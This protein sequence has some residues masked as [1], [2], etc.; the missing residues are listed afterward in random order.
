LFL[1]PS[2]LP[3]LYPIAM[4]TQAHRQDPLAAAFGFQ[5]VGSRLEQIFERDHADQPSRAVTFYH[6]KARES[7]FRHAID[8]HAQGFVGM[9]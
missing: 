4:E 3:P 9:G 6:R 8:H 1:R 2:S 5:V 7:G